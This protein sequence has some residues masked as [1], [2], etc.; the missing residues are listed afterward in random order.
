MLFSRKNIRFIASLL[1]LGTLSIG[2]RAEHE[3]VRSTRMHAQVAYDVLSRY[4]RPLMV[5]AATGATVYVG[6]TIWRVL[7]L[8]NKSLDDLE[9][10]LRSDA[11]ELPPRLRQTVK[12]A[13]AVFNVASRSNGQNVQAGNQPTTTD[14]ILAFLATEQGQAWSERVTGASLGTITPL[15]LDYSHRLLIEGRTTPGP[16]T[17]IVDA[18]LKT[19]ERRAMVKDMMVQTGPALVSQLQITLSS[20]RD[21]RIAEA[22]A[23][24]EEYVE[25]NEYTFSKLV[26]AL[27]GAPAFTTMLAGRLAF[28]MGQGLRTPVL[29][30][31]A[32]PAQEAPSRLAVLMGYPNA[33]VRAAGESFAAWLGQVNQLMGGNHDQQ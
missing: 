24:G 18:A 28:G 27:A 12:M 21:R 30:V 19:R 20:I 3:L 9:G 5:A 26:G 32:V 15:F 22:A 13:Y 33:M 25:P 4:K 10:F 17:Q 16:L 31:Q 23:R 14:Q 1:V 6:S 7:R 8:V 11:S 2:M 29:G